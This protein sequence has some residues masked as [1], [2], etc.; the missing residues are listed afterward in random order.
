MAWRKLLLTC[1][2]AA[3]LATGAHADDRRDHEMARRAMAAGDI[4]PLRVVLE[5]IRPQYPGD[6]LEVELESD[7]GYWVY[8]VKMLAPNG[9]VRKLLIDAKDA[10]LIAE[11]GKKY[12]R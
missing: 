5:R 8:K 12:R 2:T 3:A 6:V 4:L 7:Q 11:R 1:L 9:G 10:S